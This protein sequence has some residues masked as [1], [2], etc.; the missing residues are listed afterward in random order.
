MQLDRDGAQHFPAAFSLAEAAA[1]ARLLSLPET[2]AGAR[3]GSTSGLAAAIAPA[4]A[5]ARV[6]LGPAARAVGAKLFDK[7]PARNWALGWHQDR[8]IPVRERREVPGFDRWTVKSS[9]PHCVPP[10]AI[11]ERSLTL[12]IHLDAAGEANAPLLVAPGSHRLGPVAE[13]D[14]AAA[15]SR[16]GAKACLAEAGD[17]WAYATPILHASGRARAP[18]R[19]R[20]LQLLYSAEDLPGGL[21]WLRP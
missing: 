10:F 2:R 18:G 19:R 17:V 9:I 15:L 12:R 8:T 7:S 4:D 13:A 3:L 6:L 20:V 5:I 1:L 16:L 11:L 14:I 21:E